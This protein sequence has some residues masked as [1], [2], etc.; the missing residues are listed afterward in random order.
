M[1]GYRGQGKDWKALLFL[2][3]HGLENPSPNLSP[4]DVET[5]QATSLD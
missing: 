3:F 2:T 4:T 5:L 1:A